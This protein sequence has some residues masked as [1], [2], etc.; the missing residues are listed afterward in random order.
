MPVTVMVEPLPEIC[1]IAWLLEAQLKEACEIGFCEE[2]KA[3]AASDEF[4][5]TVKDKVAGD[6]CTET[7]EEGDGVPT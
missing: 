6:T 7:D 4:S 5:P 3:V 1:A 2:S